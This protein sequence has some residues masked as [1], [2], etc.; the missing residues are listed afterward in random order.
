M[1]NVILG[2]GSYLPERIVTNEDLEAIGVDY[3][4]AR[5]GNLSLDQWVRSRHG[6]VS[7]HWASPGECTSDMARAAPPPAPVDPRADP[8]GRDVVFLAPI[9]K[10]SSLPPS[11]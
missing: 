10:H 7:R 8:R 5:A 4:R 2:T 1:S 9:T 6:A 3:D 11:A